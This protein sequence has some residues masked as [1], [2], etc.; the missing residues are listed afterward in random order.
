MKRLEVKLFINESVISAWSFGAKAGNTINN[1]AAEPRVRMCA[2]GMKP[3]NTNK[4]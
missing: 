1:S 3:F 4:Y 2:E